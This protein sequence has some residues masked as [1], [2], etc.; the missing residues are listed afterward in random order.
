MLTVTPTGR[1]GMQLMSAGVHKLML[2]SMPL[3]SG[4]GWAA[5]AP[6]GAAAPILTGLLS[7]LFSVFRRLDLGC[8]PTTAAT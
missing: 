4:A 5:A 8:A 3:M 1:P 7:K 2:W 6:T